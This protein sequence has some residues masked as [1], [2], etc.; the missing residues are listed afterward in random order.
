M[1]RIDEPDTAH[2]LKLLMQDHRRVRRLLRHAEE[3]DGDPLAQAR[4]VDLA[5]R[6]LEAH[7]AIEERYLYPALRDAGG[8]D[9]TESA[10]FEHAVA[11][12]LIAAL[13][14]LGPSDAGYRETIAELADWVDDHVRVEEETL[15]A[16]AKAAGLDLA[17]L[18]AVLVERQRRGALTD[19]DV[20]AS[21]A[22]DGG[23]R[24]HT[25]GDEPSSN[26]RQRARS[27]RRSGAH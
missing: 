5:C 25:T 14:R 13:D 18:A 24:L 12:A 1:T 15:L 11:S 7:A 27:P 4:A 10:R 26:D 3:V 20:E 19:V 8:E 17:P 23:A 9:A 16:R 6:E 21:V 2:A 22:E